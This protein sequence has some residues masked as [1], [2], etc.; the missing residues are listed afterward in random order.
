MELIK[1]RLVSFAYEACTF[2][3]GIL[4]TAIASDEFRAILEQHLGTS[5]GGTLALLFF[6]GLVK[7]IR[8]TS[9]EDKEFGGTRDADQVFI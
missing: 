7:H 1:I 5:I 6:T 3:V 4:A 2:F 8:N 9:I